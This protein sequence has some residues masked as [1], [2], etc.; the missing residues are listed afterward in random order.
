MRVVTRL[1]GFFDFLFGKD[2]QSIEIPDDCIE[3]ITYYENVY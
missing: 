1:Q 3:K 2:E